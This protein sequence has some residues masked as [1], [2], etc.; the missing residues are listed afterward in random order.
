MHVHVIQA[1]SVDS[2]LLHIFY[3][4]Q[5]D[6][7]YYVQEKTDS[8]EIYSKENNYGWEPVGEKFRIQID[9]DL[10]IADKIIGGADEPTYIDLK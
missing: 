2:L 7:E 10:D 1:F 6:D 9:E 4:Q 5:L 8:D 3:R